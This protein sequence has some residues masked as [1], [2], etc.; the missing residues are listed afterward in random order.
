MPIQQASLLARIKGLSNK[1][2]KTKKSAFA[3][4]ATAFPEDLTVPGI[5]LVPGLQ[6]WKTD[7]SPPAAQNSP[8]P[9]ATTGPMSAAASTALDARQPKGARCVK[10]HPVLHPSSDGL[11]PNRVNVENPQLKSATERP[12]WRELVAIWDGGMGLGQRCEIA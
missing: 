1:R 11:Q 3:P 4:F 2:L 12:P 5:E 6:A 7:G 8:T 9:R 10:L